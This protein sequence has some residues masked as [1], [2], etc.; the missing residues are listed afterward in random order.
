[1]IICAAIKTGG[2]VVIRGQ[3]HCDCLAAAERMRTPSEFF[4]HRTEGFINSEGHFVDRIEAMH[5][6]VKS[7]QVSKEEDS[8]ELYSED[9]Y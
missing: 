3:R 7:G 4:H 6:A 2:N 9:L 8:R 1:M 5:E